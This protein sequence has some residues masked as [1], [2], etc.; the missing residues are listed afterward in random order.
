LTAANSPVPNYE[1][2][3]FNATATVDRFNFLVGEAVATPEPSSLLLLGAGLA[4]LLGAI[5][6]KLM[7]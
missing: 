1:A 3:E 7:A 2:A 4:G 6:R 5:R